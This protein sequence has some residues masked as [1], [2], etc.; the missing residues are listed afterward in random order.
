MIGV[1][2]TLPLS[3]L[4]DAAPP[5]RVERRLDW[6]GA[7]AAA[8]NI[9][10]AG[11]TAGP[12]A[13]AD[14]DACPAPGDSDRLADCAI[15]LPSLPELGVVPVVWPLGIPARALSSAAV[16]LLRGLLLLRGLGPCKNIFSLKNPAN[17]PSVDTTE[18]RG[19]F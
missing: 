8:E 2:D 16:V 1:S 19:L 9:G 12:T 15:I 14:A 18:A 13:D 6:L 10:T 3:A 11:P 17:T 5:D 4:A 7:A